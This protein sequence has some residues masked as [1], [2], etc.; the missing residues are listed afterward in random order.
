MEWSVQYIRGMP[1]KPTAVLQFCGIDTGYTEGHDGR[2][3]HL[4]LG[5]PL[6][7]VVV[8]LSAMGRQIPESARCILESSNI[9]K[10]GVNIRGD[11]Q[12]LMRDFQLEYK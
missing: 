12:K 8:H 11:G 7:C 10:I 5:H 1:Q 4:D 9:F 3:F 6:S 2:D